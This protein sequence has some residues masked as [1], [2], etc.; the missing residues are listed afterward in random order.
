MIIKS[1]CI[2]LDFLFD[3]IFIIITLVIWIQYQTLDNF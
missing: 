2:W 1:K 3:L